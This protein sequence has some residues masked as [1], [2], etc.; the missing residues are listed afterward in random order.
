MVATVGAFWSQTT[1]S[2]CPDLVSLGVAFERIAPLLWLRAGAVGPKVEKIAGGGWELPDGGRYGVLFDADRWPGFVDAVKASSTAT[3]A[4]V[5]TDS[6]AV[7]QQVVAGL[8]DGVEPV[9]LYSSYLLSFAINTGGM[10]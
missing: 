9:R 7:F 5:V 4:F 8:P 10:S 6:D 1:K 3:H 2:V